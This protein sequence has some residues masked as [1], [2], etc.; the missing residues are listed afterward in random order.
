MLFAAERASL[1]EM[2]SQPCGT[3]KIHRRAPRSVIPIKV[4][5]NL[6]LVLARRG[7]PM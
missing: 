6:N 1:G 7:E 4:T 3:G 2:A 5:H